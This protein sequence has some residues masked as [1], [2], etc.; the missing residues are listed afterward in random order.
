MSK[1]QNATQNQNPDPSRRGGAE[2]D[3]LEDYEGQ[4]AIDV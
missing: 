2:V 4:L 3:W 1:K